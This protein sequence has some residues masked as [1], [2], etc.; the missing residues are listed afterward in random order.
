M[1]IIYSQGANM[2]SKKDRGTKKPSEAPRKWSFLDT[3][4]KV[5]DEEKS[6]KTP[7]KG[8][9]EVKEDVHNSLDNMVEAEPDI[10]QLFKK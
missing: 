9:I 4:R 10:N 6:Y 2:M 7:E 5:L 1:F 8:A 3:A